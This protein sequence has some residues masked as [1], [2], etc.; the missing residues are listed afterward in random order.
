MI[1]E[2]D[3][4]GERDPEGDADTESADE[5]IDSE[6]SSTDSFGLDTD[7]EPD[8]QADEAAGAGE[9]AAE[10]DA[11]SG[12]NADAPLGSLA[13]TVDERRGRDADRPDDGLFEEES[14]P[15]I[16]SD[17][18]WEQLD[19]DEPPEPPDDAAQDVRVVKKRSYCEQCPYFSEPPEVACS[20]DGTE[21]LELVDMEHFRVVDCPIVRENER[22]EQL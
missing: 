17:V 5:R 15:E 16:D 12:A 19:Q 8:H 21:I 14:V 4:A 1:D 18:V 10:A 22:L 6:P 11:E 3:G 7:L 2:G 13:S 9:E 20:H